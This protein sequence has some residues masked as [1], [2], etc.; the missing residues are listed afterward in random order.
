MKNDVKSVDAPRYSGYIGSRIAQAVSAR[1]WTQS[2]LSTMLG[3]TNNTLGRM[4]SG[5]E[6]LNMNLCCKAMQLMDLDPQLLLSS[7]PIV[8][9]WTGIRAIDVMLQD[10]YTESSPS[11]VEALSQYTTKDYL[12]CSPSYT[13][14]S[15]YS[16]CSDIKNSQSSSNVKDRTADIVTVYDTPQHGREMLG[17]TYELER[18][19]NRTPRQNTR[20][21]KEIKQA[22]LVDENRVIVSATYRQSMVDSDALLMEY[23]LNDIY[24]LKNSFHSISRGAKVYIQRKTW[25]GDAL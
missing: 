8:G 5:Q 23:N 21:T 13:S 17:I 14:N 20:W 7:E 11:G 16:S 12:C 19:L 15:L 22:T 9:N 2:K 18:D 1:G 6:R 25:F 4:I 24:D 10:I 3:I